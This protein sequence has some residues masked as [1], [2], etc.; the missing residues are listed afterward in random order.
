M[1]ILHF[2]S[3]QLNSQ[4]TCALFVRLILLQIFSICAFATIAGFTNEVIFKCTTTY[5]FSYE[6]PF[7]LSLDHKRLEYKTAEDK[8]CNTTATIAGNF[9]SDAKFFVATGVLAMLYSIAI[10]I[11]YTKFDEL[12]RAKSQLPLCVSTD[13]ILDHY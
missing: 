9:S 8:A 13:S 1:R 12:Y 6:Y 3:K 4:G 5:E 2:V 11:V 10:I 7:E